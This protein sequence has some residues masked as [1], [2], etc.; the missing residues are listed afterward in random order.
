[1]GGRGMKPGWAADGGPLGPACGPGGKPPGRKAG[2][3]PGCPGADGPGRPLCGIS[4]AEDCCAPV[5][6][7]GRG[8][9]IARKSGFQ[10]SGPDQIRYR[11][12]KIPP[13][14]IEQATLT[15]RLIAR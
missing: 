9:E 3:R 2:R 8:P 13:E 1:M 7:P 5:G 12:A 15:C 6:G 14:D 11:Q 4:A 10:T